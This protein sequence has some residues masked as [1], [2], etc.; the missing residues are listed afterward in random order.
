M[1]QG[2]GIRSSA[3]PK[4]ASVQQGQD[5]YLVV[6]KLQKSY[7]GRK[8]V[9]GVSFMVAPGEIVGLLGRNGAGK[10]T[11]FDMV[12]GLVKPEKG[13]IRLGH[14]E[15]SK[16]PIHERSRLGISYLPQEA[17]TFR[18]LTVA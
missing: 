2:L 5:N 1:T 18:K 4:A 11:S 10:T 12:L 8:V 6:E 16:L 17:S 3:K 14:H 15:L 13:R 7:G 9:D